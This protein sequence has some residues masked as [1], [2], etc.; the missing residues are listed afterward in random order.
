MSKEAEIENWFNR[1]RLTLDLAELS[2]EQRSSGT[3]LLG[4]SGTEFVKP[5]DQ[6]D[7]N[8]IGT[9][10]LNW[11]DPKAEKI[12]ANL[13]EHHDEPIPELIPFSVSTVIGSDLWSLVLQDKDF[14]PSTA[15]RDQSQF[16]IT[17]FLDSSNRKLID[18]YLYMPTPRPELLTKIGPRWLAFEMG[19]DIGKPDR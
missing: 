15:F 1:R 8:Q 9:V 7:F 5:G 19:I 2:D 12:F 16:V 17:D 4:G 14:D 13:L 11:G 3:M 10:V 6:F 18:E